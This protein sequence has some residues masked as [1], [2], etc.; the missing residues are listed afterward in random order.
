MHKTATIRLDNE[1][2]ERIKSFSEI[3]RRSI[4][5]FIENA[6]LSYIEE[7]AFADDL[8]MMEILSNKEL[9]ARLKKGSQNVREKK[10][11][12]VG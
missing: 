10:G 1:A 8:E 11:R 7:A 5:N 4:S 3:E 2:Y 12:F 9:V 6:V